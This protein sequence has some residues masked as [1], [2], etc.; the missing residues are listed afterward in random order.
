LS[1]EEM[2]KE[3]KGPT[4]AKSGNNPEIAVFLHEILAELLLK[5]F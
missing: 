1:D 3:G 5:L 4:N 2:R